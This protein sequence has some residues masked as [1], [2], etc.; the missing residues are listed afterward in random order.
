MLKVTTISPKDIWWGNMHLLGFCPIKNEKEYTVS[1]HQY[2]FKQVSAKGMPLVVYFLLCQINRAKMKKYSLHQSAISSS[3]YAL[4]WQ[5][6]IAVIKSTLVK[7]YPSV[8]PLQKHLINA[9][10]YICS[11]ANIQSPE[12]SERRTQAQL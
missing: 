6:S 4:L 8:M 5:L 12:Q 7:K 3:F 10:T 9:T 11:P 2:L 1:C